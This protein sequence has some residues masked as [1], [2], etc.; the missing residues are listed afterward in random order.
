[1]PT[2]ST[3]TFSDTGLDFLRGLVENNNKPWFDAHRP[4]YEKGV[5]A[6]MKAL[7]EE[8]DVRFAKLAP[9][10]I[11][12]SKRSIFRI[13]RDIRFSQN[14]SLYKT[15]AA[16][17]FFHRAAASGVGADAHGSAGFYFHLE[18]GNSMFGGGLWMP[19]RPQLKQIRDAIAEDYE[20][21]DRIVTDKE[22]VKQFGGLLEEGGMLK[23]MPRGFAE[24]HP[25]AKWLKYQSFAAL[26]SLTDEQVTGRQ[27]PSLLEE[28]YARLL[29]LVRWLN[30]ALGFHPANSR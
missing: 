24:D 26:Q 28:G 19:A 18:P 23:K 9:E 5:R 15:N 27:L 25:A 17:R 8:M 20:T 12:D 10:I 6:P 7:V 22:L 14:K 4:D 2:N 13:N 16:C 21:F 30:S 3:P 11:G 1:M 29:P